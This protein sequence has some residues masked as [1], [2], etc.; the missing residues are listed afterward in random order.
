MRW[1]AFLIF[2]ALALVFDEGLGEVLAIHKLGNIRP[3]LCGV[4]A[5]F[6]ALSAPRRAALWACFVLGLLLDLSNPLSM[7]GPRIVHL[8]GPYT[9]GFVAGGR[10]V[11]QGRSMVFRRR[12]LTIGVMTCLCVMTVHVVAVT[13]LVIRTW[14]PGGPVYWTDSGAAGALLERFLIA[15]YSG[16]FAIPAGW[17]LVRTMPLWGFQTI[18]HRSG[19]MLKKA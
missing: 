8:I 4:V 11:I 13:L 6:V 19:S 10:L 5:A 2:A 7:S 18:T 17:L 3:S 16:L 9:L 15:I 12:A 1:G 14:Y